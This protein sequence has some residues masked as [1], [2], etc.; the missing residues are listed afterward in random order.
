[1][2]LMILK[3]QLTLLLPCNKEKIIKLPLDLSQL[4]EIKNIIWLKKLL[5]KL[6]LLTLMFNTK[7]K[8]VIM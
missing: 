6:E 1:M 4:V 7:K 3:N 8:I 5:P 2:K